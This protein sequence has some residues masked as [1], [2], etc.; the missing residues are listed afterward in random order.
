MRLPGPLSFEEESWRSRKAFAYSWSASLTAHLLVVGV[1]VMLVP[2]AFPTPPQPEVVTWQVMLVDSDGSENGRQAKADQPPAADATA[3]VSSEPTSG[4]LDSSSPVMEASVA[5]EVWTIPS[6]RSLF[7]SGLVQHPPERETQAV[8][9]APVERESART[10]ET[11]QVASMDEGAPMGTSE[12]EAVAVATLFQPESPVPSPPLSA[13]FSPPVSDPMV[14]AISPQ[15]EPEHSELASPL[16]QPAI[17]P[18]FSRSGTTPQNV[19]PVDEDTSVRASVP[20]DT[21]PPVSES[22]GRQQV[23]GRVSAPPDPLAG[24]PSSFQASLGAS[25]GNSGT[26]DVDY[27]W[28]VKSIRIRLME[29][30]QY[31]VE[32]RLNRYEGRVVVRAVIG[33]AGELLDVSVVQSSGHE[34]LDRDAIDLLRRVCPITMREPLRQQ[35][36]AVKVPV[37]YN[38][39]N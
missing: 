37:S 25:P 11:A 6:I 3:T 13:V 17:E 32:A 20:P 39:R 35:A 24:Q 36:V 30:K 18:P 16:S 29:L 31:P 38:L 4:R 19:A 28:L 14:S 15:A 9:P 12:R 22:D 7:R 34:V 1:A 21:G 33:E 26:R 8:R 10:V 27:G 23:A 2:R 5:A